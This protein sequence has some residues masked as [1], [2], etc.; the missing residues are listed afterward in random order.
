[1]IS[2]FWGNFFKWLEKLVQFTEEKNSKK[3]YSLCHKCLNFSRKKKKKKKNQ[4]C[5]VGGLVIF[6]K[7]TWPDLA[8]GEEGG[9]FF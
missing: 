7:R 5:E 4:F 3:S 9:R 8:A 2:K 1:L 6:H